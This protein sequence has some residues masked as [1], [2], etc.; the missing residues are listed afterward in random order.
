MVK[1]RKAIGQKAMVG[2]PIAQATGIKSW[3]KDERPREKLFK[4]GEHTQ[5]I[6]EY[7]VVEDNKI[8]KQNYDSLLLRINS[9]FKKQLRGN[10]EGITPSRT[11]TV[12][13]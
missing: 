2:H 7:T 5:A 12:R 11:R 8:Q 3:P 10:F 9:S 6:A 13:N 4:S 1:E